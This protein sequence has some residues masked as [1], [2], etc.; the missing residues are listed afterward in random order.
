MR[1]KHFL[2]RIVFPY[3]NLNV[4]PFPRA[5]ALRFRLFAACTSVQPCQTT[6]VKRLWPAA[7]FVRKKGEETETGTDR[8]KRIRKIKNIKRR[9]GRPLK[10][11]NTTTTATTTNET[12]CCAV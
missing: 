10:G 4:A 2:A 6:R 11:A 1:V 7:A 3:V 8:G 9:S 5:A 12:D